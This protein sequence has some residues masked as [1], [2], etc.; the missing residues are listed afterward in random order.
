[1]K[2][3]EQKEPR[4]ESA[5]NLQIFFFLK[6]IEENR[7]WCLGQGRQTE[8]PTRQ[9]FH[10][11]K[12]DTDRINWTSVRPLVTG[13]FTERKQNSSIAADFWL[14]SKWLPAE[15]L[16]SPPC[17]VV[18][19]RWTHLPLRTQVLQ[20][21]SIANCY[22]IFK[23]G[24][25]YKPGQFFSIVNCRNSLPFSEVASKNNTVQINEIEH[26]WENIWTCRSI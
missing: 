19:H 3:N 16:W 26:D 24:F 17:G 25:P 23:L 10:I 1:V 7:S 11:S 12:G 14:I 9:Y 8:L 20:E 15:K 22:T 4:S 18:K 21:Y 5:Y 6:I 2:S 13:F